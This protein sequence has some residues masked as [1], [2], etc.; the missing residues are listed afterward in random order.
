MA[1]APASAE[2]SPEAATSQS[3]TVPK[4]ADQ[5][6]TLTATTGPISPNG[7]ERSN[8]AWLYDGQTPGPELRVA[9]GD[10]LQVSLE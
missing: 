8:P 6:R 4:N 7:T 2:P 3:P 5:Q 1:S 9:E 10:V